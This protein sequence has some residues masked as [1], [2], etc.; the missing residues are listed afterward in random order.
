M[1]LVTPTLC[2]P[3]CQGQEKAPADLLRHHHYREGTLKKHK[4]PANGKGTAW[5]QACPHQLQSGPCASVCSVSLDN[6]DL[7]SSGA[8][9]EAADTVSDL[10]HS[11]LEESVLTQRPWRLTGPTSPTASSYT[12][13]EFSV[14]FSVS[15]LLEPIH[16]SLHTT[17]DEKILKARVALL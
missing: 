7:P 14:F 1:F 5:E 17:S 3:P 2:A 15:G 6:E 10:V 8:H 11:R 16:T 9:L 12:L 13:Q 4:A